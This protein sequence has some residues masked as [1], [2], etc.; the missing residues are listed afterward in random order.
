MRKGVNKKQSALQPQELRK[1]GDKNIKL[2]CRMINGGKK[3][4]KIKTHKKTQKNTN[5]HKKN[6]TNKK[7]KQ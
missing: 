3:C 1:T 7:S 2:E 4:K 5:K 6:T